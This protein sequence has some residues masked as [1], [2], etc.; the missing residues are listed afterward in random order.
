MNRKIQATKKAIEI[1]Q[2]NQEDAIDVLAKVGGIY[3]AG[4]GWNVPWRC[5]IWC[6]GRDRWIYFLCGSTDRA[7]YLSCRWEII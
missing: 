5:G 1:N 4:M 3:I 2:P 7:A 6:P